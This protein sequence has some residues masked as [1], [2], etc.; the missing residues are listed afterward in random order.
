MNFRSMRLWPAVHIGAIGAVCHLLVAGLGMP[1]LARSGNPIEIIAFGDSLMSGLGLRSQDSFP[2]QLERALKDRGHA[3]EVVGAGVSGDT[4]A[5]GLQ[6][7]EWVVPDGAD[8]VILELG[9]NDAL[10]GLNPAATRANLEMIIE[11]LK[12]KGARVLLAGMKAPRNWGE[13]YVREFEPIFPELA[14]KHQL[15]FYPFFLEGV[16]LEPRLVLEDGLHPNARGIAKMV[17]GILP[18]VEELIAKVE[19]A[20]AAANR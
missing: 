15:V 7:V 10:R 11:R 13:A 8:A 16:A 14:E 19:A 2:E 12:A 17:E 20:R 4:T 6:R 5:G 3:V 9:A 1:A 18:A